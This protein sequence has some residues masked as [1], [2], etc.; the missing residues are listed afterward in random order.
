[1]ITHGE[2]INKIKD[3]YA[4]DNK[5]LFIISGY[6]GC[7]K[8]T[9]AKTIPSILKI[10]DY[11]FLTPTGIAAT[12]LSS[13]ARTVHSYLYNTS[14]HPV[15]QELI[16]QKKSKFDFDEELLIVDE[17]SM[18]GDEILNDLRELEIPIVGLGDPQQLPPVNGKNS[19]LENS[20]IFLTKVWRNDNG[21]LELAT[22][23]RAHKPIKKQYENVEFRRSIFFDF[24]LIGE[25]SVVICR[26]NKTRRKLNEEIRKRIY[27]FSNVL[28]VGER[29]MILQN[30]R[31]TGLSNGS[32]VEI[33]AINYLVDDIVKL[34]IKTSDGQLLWIMAGLYVIKNLERP[35]SADNFRSPLGRKIRIFDIDYAYA[36]TCHKSQGS[37]FD[38]VFVI[39]EGQNYDD[40]D[41]WFYTAVTRAK[42]KLYIY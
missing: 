20:D 11:A 26:Y 16:F 28:H 3:W 19:I 38:R 5:R 1:M 4:N 37:E 36:I 10:S 15:T 7:G 30:D 39:R 42:K 34:N 6:A 12:V 22:D 31:E 8:T 13:D 35:K 29:I 14:V 27:E 41:K 21:I 24:K 17:I 23:I 18:V 32:I 25:D 2:Q 40:W 33:I 9:F